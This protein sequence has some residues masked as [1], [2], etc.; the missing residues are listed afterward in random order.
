MH[1]GNDQIYVKEYSK[2]KKFLRIISLSYIFF[3]N[4]TTLPAM[5]TKNTKGQI[6]DA[7]KKITLKTSK[8]IFSIVIFCDNML[9]A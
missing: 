2:P 5:P 8:N 1:L 3:I 9:N 7:K 4:K 6:S